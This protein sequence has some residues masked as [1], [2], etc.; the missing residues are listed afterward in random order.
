MIEAPAD[1]AEHRDRAH[2]QVAP[3]AF[4]GADDVLCALLF[5]TCLPLGAAGKAKFNGAGFHAADSMAV[6]SLQASRFK[7]WSPPMDTRACR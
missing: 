2:M 3:R 5:P 1:K 4:R 7:E 6:Y